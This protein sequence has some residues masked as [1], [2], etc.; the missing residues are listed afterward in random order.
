M[1]IEIAPKFNYELTY[2]EAFLYCITLRYNGCN[3][4]RLPSESE[5]GYYKDLTFSWYEDKYGN[6]TW[7]VTPVRDL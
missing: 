6:D 3:D 7:A 2:D 5:Y 4:W 1:S